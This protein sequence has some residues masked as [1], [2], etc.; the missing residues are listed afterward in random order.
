MVITKGIRS[1][2][3][4]YP[5]SIR[6][7]YHLSKYHECDFVFFSNHDK[8]IIS[9]QYLSMKTEVY[10][11]AE[12]Y[13]IAFDFVDVKKQINLFEEFISKYSKIPVKS[14]M[15]IACG[16]ALQLR[17]F[18][19]RGYKSTG[20]DLSKDMLDY[21]K[22]KSTQEKS[23]IETVK[24][25]MADFMLNQ[26]VDFAYIL[27]GSIVYLKNNK[28]LISHLKSVANTLNSGGLYIIENLIINWAD[29]KTWE[30]RKWE[31]ERGKIKVD[32]F[33][34]VSLKNELAQTIEQVIKL[35]INDNG[36]SMTLEDRDE[37]KLVMPQEFKT[38]VELQDDFEFIGFFERRKLEELT[39]SSSY[40][41]IV[42][43]KK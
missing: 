22:Q 21:L 25:N 4:G 12:Y 23:D 29:P 34:Q 14:V 11:Q 17:E 42:L 30:S 1:H 39:K 6:N 7:F 32:I 10:Q 18:A 5:F 37:L 43:R 31:M 9:L 38:I 26:K 16:P 24:A 35:D 2:K 33:Y 13:E 27:M 36:K 40:N 20:L 3:Y 19:K 41:L 15:D 8:L 28:E